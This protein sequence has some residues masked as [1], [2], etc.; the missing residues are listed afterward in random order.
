MIPQVQ[1]YQNKSSFRAKLPGQKLAVVYENGKKVVSDKFV[2][3][4]PDKQESVINNLKDMFF[5]IFPDLDKEYRKILSQQKNK[6]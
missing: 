5:E 2:K 3:R 1:M 4:N 6:V